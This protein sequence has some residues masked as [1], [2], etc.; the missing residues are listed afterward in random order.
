MPRWRTDARLAGT[1]TSKA[2]SGAGPS[3][4]TAAAI[5][6]ASTGAMLRRSRVF[7]IRIKVSAGGA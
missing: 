2:P 6:R 1:G 7:S 3:R 4:A 5:I